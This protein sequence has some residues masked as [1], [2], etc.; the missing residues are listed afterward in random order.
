MFAAAE[1]FV[2]ASEQCPEL[3]MPMTVTLSKSAFVVVNP[4]TGLLPAG[5]DNVPLSHRLRRFEV[6]ELLRIVK[7]PPVTRKYL[8]GVEAPGVMS[9]R[10]IAPVFPVLPLTGIC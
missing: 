4:A 8:C 3:V 6:N 10:S 1:E 7:H 9:N 2:A 5:I